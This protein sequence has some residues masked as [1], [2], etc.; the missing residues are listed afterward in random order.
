MRKHETAGGEGR[1]KQTYL[2]DMKEE[3]I[4]RQEVELP[5]TGGVSSVGCPHGTTGMEQGL[6]QGRNRSLGF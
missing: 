6:G 5:L 1:V 2:K 3:K 4:Q